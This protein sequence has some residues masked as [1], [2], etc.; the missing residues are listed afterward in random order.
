MDQFNQ[1]MQ[2]LLNE[3]MNRAHQQKSSEYEEMLQK[4]KMQ[5]IT[6]S[7]LP[8]SAYGAIMQELKP[9]S[10]S[11]ENVPRLWQPLAAKL[12]E[13]IRRK[14][15]QQFG[16]IS[17]VLRLLLMNDCIL[18]G[19]S[20]SSIFH[21][22]E[23]KDYDFWLKPT[24]FLKVEAIR[25]NIIEKYSDDILDISENYG[26]VTVNNKPDLCV[27]ANAITFKN[28]FQLITIA[29]Y[30]SARKT[31]DFVHC[32]PYFDFAEDKFFISEQQFKVIQ[33]KRL[34]SQ[35]PGNIIADFRVNK[36]KSRGWTQ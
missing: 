1:M 11:A 23:P 31:F 28:K 9:A 6:N 7:T 26:G 17:D 30:Y 2:E 21:G 34:V 32:L 24:P 33:Q 18:S 3:K 13:D 22:E 19:S 15:S 12:K 25:Q 36:F 27:T 20:I 8:A 10:W 5:Q 35:N 4:V 14:V 29:D 16:G